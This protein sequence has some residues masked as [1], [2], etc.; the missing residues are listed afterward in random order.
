MGLFWRHPAFLGLLDETFLCLETS[1]ASGQGS[2][3]PVPRPRA[4]AF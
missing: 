1:K 4:Q 3:E 2:R